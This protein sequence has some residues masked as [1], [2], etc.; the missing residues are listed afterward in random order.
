MLL[1]QYKIIFKEINLFYAV[2]FFL[3]SS[4]VKNGLT[5]SENTHVFLANQIREKL[6]QKMLVKSKIKRYVLI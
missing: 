1:F 3:A 2:Y 4:F 5:N 6:K